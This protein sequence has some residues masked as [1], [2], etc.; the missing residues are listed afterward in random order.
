MRLLELLSNKTVPFYSKP[1]SKKTGQSETHPVAPTETQAVC[2][3]IFLL[4]TPQRG[5]GLET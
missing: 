4:H 2:G 1:T 5:S 3:K